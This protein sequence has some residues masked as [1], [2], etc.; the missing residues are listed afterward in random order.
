MKNSLLIAAFLMMGL[1]LFP[2]S[3]SSAVYQFYDSEG[4]LIITNKKGDLPLDG[5]YRVLSSRQAKPTGRKPLRA[6][7]STVRIVSRP[8]PE[9]IADRGVE[10]VRFKYYEVCGRTAR[11]AIHQS[12]ER[13]PYDQ[14]EGRGYPGQTKWSLGWSYDYSYEMSQDSQPGAVLARAEVYNVEV[15]ADVE[16]LLPKLSSGC[17]L[18]PNE[19][20]IWKRSM[21]SLRRHELDHVNL[22]MNQDALQG[23][24]D[25]IAGMRDY[26]F[27]HSGAIES[28]L[29]RAVQADTHDDGVPWIRWIKDLND[30]YDRVT[31]HGLKPEY[32]DDFFKNL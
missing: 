32:R 21:D 19:M 14:R 11:E 4:T 17:T 30:E 28:D 20:A 31:E 24:A 2:G 23:M 15:Y 26:S 18:P 8:A 12:V 27:T 29:R 1:P 22:V 3:A 10:G 5:A 13:G 7:P 16:V 9:F 6:L 25:S